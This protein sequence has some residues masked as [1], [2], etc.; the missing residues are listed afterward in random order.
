[1]DLL[2]VHLL[3]VEIVLDPLLALDV[4]APQRVGDELLGRHRFDR[5]QHVARPRALYLPG[6]RRA[7]VD[8]VPQLPRHHHGVVAIARDVGAHLLEPQVAPRLLR[9]PRVHARR[10]APVLRVAQRLGKGRSGLKGAKVLQAHLDPNA[11]LPGQLH[12]AVEPRKARQVE[13]ARYLGLG[14]KAGVRQP[15]P[16]IVGAGPLQLAEPAPVF[17]GAQRGR[18]ARGGEMLHPLGKGVAR[19]GAQAQADGAKGIPIREGQVARIA[20]ADLDEPARKG[21]VIR[22]LALQGIL[23]HHL[24]AAHSAIVVGACG[25]RGKAHGRHGVARRNGVLVAVVVVDEFSGLMV[26]RGSGLFR[27]V[28]AHEHD[29]VHPQEAVERRCPSAVALHSHRAPHVV[30]APG[31]GQ[32]SVDPAVVAGVTACGRRGRIVGITARNAGAGS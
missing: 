2:K 7:A 28:G 5:A 32:A 21:G 26:E 11:V 20:R 6:T 24:I 23:I 4:K 27:A 3:H 13:F 15:Q 1:M 9:E 16:H 14:L 12:D 18:I 22:G 8:L 19:R 29:A 17:G 30:I 25:G 10:G 31:I